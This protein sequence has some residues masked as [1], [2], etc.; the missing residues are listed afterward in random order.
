MTEIADKRLQELFSAIMVTAWKGDRQ[1]AMSAF[2]LALNER[3]AAA[4]GTA[5][6]V[7]HDLWCQHTAY[8]SDGCTCGADEALAR[9]RSTQPEAVQADGLSEQQH[10]EQTHG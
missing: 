8:K 10:E 1:A 2:I 4:D 3:L 5:K 7:M 9:Y 6:H